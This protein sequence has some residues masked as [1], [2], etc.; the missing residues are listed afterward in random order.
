MPSVIDTP[1]RVDHDTHDLQEEQPQVRVARSG[2][3]HRLVQY[4]RRHRVHTSFQTRSSGHSARCQMESPMVV[5]R[6]SIRRSISWDSV[7]SIL[8]NTRADR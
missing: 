2:F 7:A 1:V 3:W 4:V 5:W 6:R 8:Y